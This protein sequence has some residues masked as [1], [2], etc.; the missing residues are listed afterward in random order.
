MTTPAL[1]TK[2]VFTITAE[3]GDV[4]GPGKLVRSRVRDGDILIETRQGRVEADR[5]SRRPPEAPR[6]RR[7]F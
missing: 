5:G 1:E 7:L 2:Y 3:I 6:L 4:T